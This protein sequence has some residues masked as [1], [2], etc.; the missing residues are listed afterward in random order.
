MIKQ[1]TA[2]AKSLKALPATEEH[3]IQ[4]SI[5]KIQQSTLTETP[6]P[7]Y[8]KRRKSLDSIRTLTEKQSIAHQN[9]VGCVKP[10]IRRHQNEK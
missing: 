2:S 8:Q 3:D 7:I 4:N 9:Q 10:G 6:K 5:N 1:E